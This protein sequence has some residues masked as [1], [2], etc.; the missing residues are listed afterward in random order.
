MGAA[1]WGSGC[2]RADG[3]D[4]KDADA[5]RGD[6]SCE[7]SNCYGSDCSDRKTEQP[8][9]LRGSGSA[10]PVFLQDLAKWR[11]HNSIR[12]RWDP[13][14]RG[15]E[16]PECIE[17]KQRHGEHSERLALESGKARYQLYHRA[18]SKHWRRWA[19][20]NNNMINNLIF[21]F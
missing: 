7:S 5:P 4:H 16:V 9:T 8:A 19:F 10:R 21:Q 18:N 2:L 15:E 1:M 11:L 17:S 3:V 13:H 20:Y 6:P 12:S 14:D